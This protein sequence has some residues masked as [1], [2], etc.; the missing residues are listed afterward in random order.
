MPIAFRVGETE[1]CAKCHKDTG[2]PKNC[3]VDDPRRLGC[4]VEGAGQLCSECYNE[5]YG[6]AI[7]SSSS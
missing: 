5:V 7:P 4:Y 1:E 3:H 2:I 6:P